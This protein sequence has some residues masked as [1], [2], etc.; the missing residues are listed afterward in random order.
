MHRTLAAILLLVALLLNLAVLVLPFVTVTIGMSTENYSLVRSV[1]MLWEYGFPGLAVLVGLFSVIFPF[2]K[3]A[4]LAGVCRGRLGSG[5]ATTIGGLGKW[6]MLDLFLVVLLI[7]VAYDRVMVKAVP[8]LGL[9][10]FF[11][12]IICSMIAGELLH[13]A[14]QLHPPS[15]RT[16]STRVLLTLSIAGTLLALV[17]PLF[18]TDAWFLADV[19]FSMVG[20]IRTLSLAGALVPAIA[21]ALFLVLMPLVRLVCLVLVARRG[22]KWPAR[23]AWAGRW[24]MHEPFALALA[25]FIVEGRDT[26]PTTLAEG[27]F[28]LL[29]AIM[30]SSTSA[31]L[32]ARTGA[33]AAR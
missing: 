6:S 15:Q 16:W 23:A 9:L 28:V 32:L 26:I 12:A 22:G 25:I 1:H 33:V 7:A 13:P 2:A 4:V 27:S 14:S 19:S 30:V 8:Q 20:M 18:V 24:A 5:W 21:V 17:M 10:C 29:A 3:I 11:V 31:W